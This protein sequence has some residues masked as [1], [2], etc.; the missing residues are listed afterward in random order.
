MYNT[1]WKTV[2]YYIFT[3]NPV[4]QAKW[5]VTGSISITWEAL[6]NARSWIPRTHQFRISGVGPGIQGIFMHTTFEMH[7]IVFF[8]RV[9][10]GKN[11]TQKRK[12]SN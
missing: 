12:L 4:T 1:L 5:G 7:S 8:P 6:R 11:E 10:G 3:A 2:A 9:I